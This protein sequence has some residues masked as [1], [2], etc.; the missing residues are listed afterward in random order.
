MKNIEIGLTEN[1][2]E[3]TR[4]NRKLMDQMFQLLDELRELRDKKW[5]ISQREKTLNF[6]EKILKDN[7]ELL[8]DEFSKLRQDMTRI[9]TS[10]RF[11]NLILYNSLNK[12]KEII[13]LTGIVKEI[14]EIVS[15]AYK[16]K[17]FWKKFNK[18]K[19]GEKYFED[20]QEIF[21]DLRENY[22]WEENDEILNIMR[23][24]FLLTPGQ[25]KSLPIPFKCKEVRKLL[26]EPD[27]K[28]LIGCRNKA[29]LS[30]M[31]YTGAK[32]SQIC[33]LR[34]KDYY[35]E[36]SEDSHPV[37]VFK[38]KKENNIIRVH[39]E[40]ELDLNRYLEKM[41]HGNDHE[42]PLIMSTQR[43]ELIKT[44][45]SIDDSQINK[46]FHKH[47]EK[48][49]LPKLPPHST[50]L[51]F[52][53]ALAK[54]QYSNFIKYL[55]ALEKADE[56]FIVAIEKAPAMDETQTTAQQ[57][58]KIQLD[59]IKKLNGIIERMRYEI[60]KKIDPTHLVYK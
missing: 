38:K 59:A 56:N 51:T 10:W 44:K 5:D 7:E 13:F 27:V 1:E 48:V 12:P 53:W 14:E 21:K 20:L 41:G 24:T 8:A 58:I 45:K 9:E 35:Y 26:E 28:T 16:R 52:Q 23:D 37:I 29:I 4:Y 19:K 46:I 3:L 39:Q 36:H 18:F 32:V 33:K 50:K 34:V 42:A 31:F 57:V 17:F 15:K 6:K 55:N 25:K 11:I 54:L 40:L 49:G 30:L 47:L 2:V 60:L 22:E 43:E